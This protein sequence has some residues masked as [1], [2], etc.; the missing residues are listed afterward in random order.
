MHKGKATGSELVIFPDGTLY[1]IDLKQK[2]AIPRNLLLMGAANR[3]DSVAKH[4]DLITFRHR[5]KARPEFYLV[6][7]TYKKTPVA[8]F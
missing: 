5:N 4:F 2:D 1:H 6:A 8:A 3:V 7:G